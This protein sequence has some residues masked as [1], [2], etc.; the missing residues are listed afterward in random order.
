LKWQAEI[1]N[2]RRFVRVIYTA[3]GKT[4]APYVDT[5][6]IRKIVCQLVT[7]H[8]HLNRSLNFREIRHRSSLQKNC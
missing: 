2:G 5:T 3:K 8:Q 1:F 4:E 7:L 6:L